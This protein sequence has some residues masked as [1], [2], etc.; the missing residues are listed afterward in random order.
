M[1]L[2]AKLG[3]AQAGIG[4]IGLGNRGQEGSAGGVAGIFGGAGKVDGDGAGKGD[5]AGGEGL[6]LHLGQHAADVGVVNDR[7]RPVGGAALLAVRGKAQGVLEGGLGLGNALDAD[8]K[9]GVV[10]HGE[11]GGHALVRRADQPARG[12]VELHDSGGRAVDAKLVFE[13]DNVERVARA[14]VAGIIGQE[15]R[16]H[17]QRDALHPRLGVGQAG[18]DQMAGIGHEIA[19]APGDEDLLAG[20]RKAAV[21][22]RLGLGAERADIGAGL[23]FGQVHRAVPCARDQFG[24][25]DGLDLIGSVVVQ[26]LD[27]A[28]GQHGVQLQSKAGRGHHLGHAGIEGDGQAHAAMRRV[29]GQADPAAVGDGAEAFG[30]TGR[31]AHDAVFKPGGMFVAGA[32][33]RGKGGFGQPGRLGQ[34]GG[35]GVG[36]GIG[37]AFGGGDGGEIQNMIQQ[38]AEI[39][40]GGA[41]G[42]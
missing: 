30:K 19:V 32:V 5:G 13:A 41:V 27:L 24:Q 2:H 14:G 15:F 28:L 18:E 17:E 37:K 22:F 20:D 6:G 7:G 25:V 9:A 4:A 36:R 34:N 35:G 33:Q 42:H 29:G 16:D 40:G 8:A 38:K 11:H 31:G 21:G 1:D 23:R 26:R 3:D 39:G 12:A 10:H